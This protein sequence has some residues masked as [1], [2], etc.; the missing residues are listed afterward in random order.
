MTKVE[1]TV[2]VERRE[3]LSPNMIRMVLTGEPLAD[4]PE[5]FESGY[6]KLLLPGVAAK[7]TVRSYTIRAFSPEARELTLDMVAHGDAGPATSWAN[8]AGPGTEITITGPG[9]VKKINPDADWFLLAGDMSAFPA[10]SVNLESLPADAE[11]HVVLEVISEADKLALE[12]PGGL[13][14]HWIV[15]PEPESPNTMLEDTV[16]ALPWSDGMASVWVAG[17]FSASRRL[18]QYFRHE[19][20]LDK[21]YMYVSCYWKVGATD[22]G[23]KAAKRA[24]PEP[25]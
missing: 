3:Q 12:L 10:I 14:V 22:E 9:A 2:S 19:R 16:M 23:M 15:N 8:R 11:G 21:D 18:R 13:K 1:R 17:E 4:F 24:D 7:P 6:V 5:G 20:G 25:W